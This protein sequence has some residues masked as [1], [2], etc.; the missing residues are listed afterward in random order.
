MPA[1]NNIVLN[2]DAATPVAWTF[3]PVDRQNG[4]ARFV[5]RAA[6]NYD[7]HMDRVLHGQTAQVPSNDGGFRTT[8]K[9]VVPFVHTATDHNSASVSTQSDIV[10]GICELSF[11]I[12]GGCTEQDRKDILSM[13][14]DLLSHADI[15]SMV[16]GAENFYG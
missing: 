1:M 5:A 4:K 9:L 14:I 2:D 16:V 15:Y 3:K 10:R 12:P 6:G 7:L 8:L 13:S 11:R